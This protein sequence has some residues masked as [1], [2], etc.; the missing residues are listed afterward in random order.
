MASD[1][2]AYAG[3]TAAYWAFTLT[4]GALRML[5]LLHFHRLGFSP[6]DLAFLFLLYEVMGIVTN[7]AGGWIGA[8]FGLRV[9]LFGGLAVQIVALLMLSAVDPAWAVGLSVAYVMAAQALSGVAKDL[10]KMSSKSAVKVVVREAEDSRGLL[11]KWVALLT[12]SKNALKGVGFF[13]GGAL[14]T[15]VGFVGA[16]WAMAA[17]LAVVLALAVAGLRADLGKAR[18]KVAGRDLFSKTADINWLSAARV[19]LF[20]SRD[21][22]FVVGVPIFLYAELGWSFDRVGAFMAVWVIGYGIVQAAVPK[23]LRSTHDAATASRAA[24]LWGALLALLPAA[25]AV[26]MGVAPSAPLLIGGLLVFGV[27]FAVN[28]AVHS[29]LIVA[30]SDADKV[31]LNVGF[32]YMANAVGRL[33][34]TLASGVVYQLAGL[35]ATLWVSAAMVAIAV[36]FTL[37]LGR[38][39]VGQG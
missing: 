26:G 20:A 4:D 36:A 6:I 9:T 16:L 3:V 35:T 27:V 28:S 14:L 1:L 10:T 30:F 34:G 25:L 5:V 17:M 8:R 24:K 32:Y 29:Y 31:A 7:L 37:P 21:V 39:R 12:G 23:L 19:F 2:R 33:A 11:F 18:S 13:L 22:W 38:G 15:W